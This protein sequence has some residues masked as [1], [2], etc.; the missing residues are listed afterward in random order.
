MEIVCDANGN[1]KWISFPVDSVYTDNGNYISISDWV[2][3]R[4]DG[5]EKFSFDSEAEQEW[6]NILKDIASSDA[7]SERNLRIGKRVLVGKKNPQAGQLTF[8][9]EELP[10]KMN[11]ENKYL[12]GKNFIPNSEIKFEYCLGGV[13]SS[14]PDFIFMDCFDRIHIFEVKG[15]NKSNSQ[16][17]D[18]DSDNYE[19]K[20]EELKRSYKQASILTG[21]YFYVPM[22]VG[23]EWLIT[24]IY[25]GTESILSMSQ[26]RRFIKSNVGS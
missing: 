10:Q 18:S 5:K 9:G 4:K 19:E 20:I 23:D 22:L 8:E 15:L 26:F 1:E 11:G 14:Y 7:E 12:W 13:H 2:W 17:K 6:A 24:Q 25:N 3:K 21:Y 16:F